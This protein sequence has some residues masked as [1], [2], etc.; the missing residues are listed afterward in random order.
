MT[1]NNSSTV[2]QIEPIETGSVKKDIARKAVAVAASA[3]VLI[4]G[5]FN[6]PADIMQDPSEIDRAFPPPAAVQMTIDSI[7]DDDDGSLPT[8]DEE[9]TEDEEKKRGAKDSLRRFVLRIPAPVRAVVLV[10]MWCVGWVLITGLT[11][12]WNAVLSPVMSTVVG[13]LCVAAVI[14][15]IVLAAVKTV[16]P[17]LPVKKILNKKTLIVI[18]AGV[19]LT[20]CADA[21]L[22][23][24][25]EGYAKFRGIARF[26]A[27]TAVL[28]CA[29]V[30]FFVKRHSRG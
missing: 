8:G 20:A 16:F 29:A 23:L 17:E 15:L 2:E 18:A 26:L 24:F 12:L 5:L 11:A 21:V 13:W 14:A 10:P 3:S 1:E 25:S 7:D 30:P 4:G 6:S 22:P 19:A 9:E 28:S 27:S